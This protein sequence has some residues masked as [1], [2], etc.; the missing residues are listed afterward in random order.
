M[1]NYLVHI[2]YAQQGTGSTARHILDNP[3]KI[4]NIL[5]LI[6]KILQIIMEIGLPIIAIALVYVGFKYVT[7]QG[8]PGKIKEAHQAFL[9]VVI[10]AAI[11][12]GAIVIRTIIQGTVDSLQ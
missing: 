2:A 4:N 8:N 7:A 11:V 12:L 1:F 9:W 10:G 5:D 6:T 3:I